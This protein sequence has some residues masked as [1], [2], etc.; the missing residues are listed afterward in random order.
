[1]S[2]VREV[3]RAESLIAQFPESA[4]EILPDIRKLVLRKFRYSFLYSI[5]KDGLLI[6]A[7]AHRGVKNRAMDRPQHRDLPPAVDRAVHR[8]GDSGDDAAG[9][10]LRQ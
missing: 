5:E 8:V 7:M 4:P 3:R 1:M 6:L 2:P 9:H 10:A